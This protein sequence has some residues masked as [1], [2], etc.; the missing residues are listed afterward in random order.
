MTH[1][2]DGFYQ[3]LKNTAHDEIVDFRRTTVAVR[4]FLGLV[5]ISDGLL[6]DLR[7]IERRLPPTQIPPPPAEELT[8]VQGFTTIAGPV[9]WN[10][11]S[12]TVHIELACDPAVQGTNVTYSF[13]G[14]GDIVAC[15][16]SGTGG[17]VSE[18]WR[19]LSGHG[20]SPMCGAWQ[21]GTETHPWWY[22][23]TAGHYA[24]VHGERQR[25]PLPDN[26][27]QM[28]DPLWLDFGANAGARVETSTSFDHWP[29]LGQLAGYESTKHPTFLLHEAADQLRFTLP[30]HPED[31]YHRIRP[32]G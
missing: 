31:V 16:V 21:G 29:M 10:G 18:R 26:A 22:I 7:S 8:M 27:T 15:E 1:P 17:T 11:D 6:I 30:P 3:V 9:T 2:G 24:I 23:C 28:S 13:S 12:A 5:A 19:R 25:D 4:E 32:T 14:D 20:E